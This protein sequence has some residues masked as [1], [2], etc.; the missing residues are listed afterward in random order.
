AVSLSAK[1]FDGDIA[2]AL[3]QLDAFRVLCAHRS[4]PFGVNGWNVRAERL[5]ERAEVQTRGHYPGQPIMVTANDPT[6]RLFNGDVGVVVRDDR[7]L[8]VAFPNSDLPPIDPVSLSD[9][10]TVHA[11]TIHKS[12][13]SEF[14][15]VVVV[16]PPE[17]SRL[18]TRELL[19]TAVT[20]ARRRVTLVGSRASVLAALSRS[21]RRV[22]GLRHR[23]ETAQEH[24]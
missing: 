16:L 14:D 20:R 24:G 1:V 22:S 3:R 7:G 15:H 21:E 13:G 11:M 12:Q 23:L 17:G 8:W 2:G 9:H 19:Y 10:T 6:R 5:L 18:A 4:G